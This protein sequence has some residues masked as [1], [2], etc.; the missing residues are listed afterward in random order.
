MSENQDDVKEYIPRQKRKRMEAAKR[1]ARMQSRRNKFNFSSKK[2]KQKKTIVKKLEPEDPEDV[3]PK[4]SSVSLLDQNHAMMKKL[5]QNPKWMLEL[6]KEEESRITEEASLVQVNSIMSIE[7]VAKGIVY[8]ES[9]K[10]S[11]RP[12][13]K[14]RSMSQSQCDSIRKK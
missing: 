10:T 1:R 11:W 7:E 5:K 14:I 8:T 4:R 12:P 9:M 3:A 2:M 13:S 6:K